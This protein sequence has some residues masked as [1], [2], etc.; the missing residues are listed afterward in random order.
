VSEPSKWHYYGG[1]FVDN[2][3]VVSGGIMRHAKCNIY[4]DGDGMSGGK[5]TDL[6]T[7]LLL[8]AEQF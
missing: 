7:F 3:P 2:V 8:G 4:L 5:V 1:N 6:N